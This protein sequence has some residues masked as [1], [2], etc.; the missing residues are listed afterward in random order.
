MTAGAYTTADL[1]DRVRGELRGRRDLPIKGVNSMHEAAPDEITFIADTA[2]ARL[3]PQ[4]RA[5]AAL[6]TR[7]VEPGALEPESRAFIVVDDAELAVIEVLRLFAPADPLPD[8]GVHPTAVVHPA[9]TLGRDVRIGPH[10]SVDRSAR[11]EDRVVLHAGVRIYAG[12]SVGADSVLH[13]NTVVRERCRIGRRVIL[14]QGVAI[15][16][17]GFNYRPAPDG[18]GLCKV[19]HIGIV[20]LEDDVEIGANSSVDRAKFGATL[21][22]R[23]TKI[24]NLVQIGHNCRIGRHTVIAGCCGLS[25]SVVVGDRV[26]I[27]GAVGIADHITVGDG[28]S[29]G[30]MSFV[31][32]DVPPGQTRV[33]LPAR[34][35]FRTFR[36]WAA[37]DRLP[38]LL[39]QL[40][41]RSSEGPPE[42]SGG[43]LR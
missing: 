40:S 3:W 26:Q 15:G 24:D 29:I 18:S 14:H 9:A 25:G 27:G 6:V 16:A 17:D 11:I 23:G 28:A 2:H 7:G 10:V 4:A 30:G 36:A 13:A 19:P 34:E 42:G 32:R 31:V 37:L 1:A 39:R 22:G 41:R 33:G 5:R 8:P 20:I 43:G 12:A 21:I 35:A 38:E